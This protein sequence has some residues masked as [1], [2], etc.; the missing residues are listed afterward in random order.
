MTSKDASNRSGAATPARWA[1]IA[2]VLLAVGILAACK[3]K[4]PAPVVVV[5]PPPP[6]IARVT[7]A[8]SPDVNPNSSG[9]A[10]PIYVRLY[11][12][13]DG[14]KF[15][16]GEFED[17]TTRSDQVLAAAIVA[18]EERIVEPGTTTTLSLAVLPETRLLGV[19]AEYR[20]LAASRWRAVSPAPD[21]GLLTLFKDHSLMVNVDRQAVAV[22]VVASTKGK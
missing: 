9:R 1:A 18:R 19:V 20:D 2:T 11:Q 7:I 4:P 14:A 21:G 3:T 6:I 12:L 22:S 16:T 5:T 13:R 15:Q 8:V 17:L 10:S